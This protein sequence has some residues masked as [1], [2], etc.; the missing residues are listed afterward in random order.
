MS[1]GPKRARTT[2]LPL[3]G[4]AALLAAAAWAL[5]LHAQPIK[6]YGFLPI[7]TGYPRFVLRRT[8]VRVRHRRQLEREAARAAA[9]PRFRL[10]PNATL[11]V[12]VVSLPGASARRASVRQ[13]LCQRNITFAWWD[14]VDGAAALPEDEVR[15]YTSGPR[16]AAFRRGAPGSRAHRK[17]ACDLS[18]L[19]L[20]HD[21]VAQGREVQVVLEDDAQLADAGGDFLARVRG[22]LA[23]L[24]A[25]WDVLWLNH[26]G[27]IARE[28]ASLGPWVG[29]GV[30]TFMDNSDTVGMAYRRSFALV[31][32]AR[33]GGASAGPPRARLGPTDARVAA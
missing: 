29:R 1:G 13:Q 25:G 30:R 26:G 4:L 32:S 24:P 23:Q 20:M 22:A 12:F 14:A 21:M 5:A 17:A 19:R 18:H 10:A 31:V 27:P 28:P 2:R 3:V 16:L 6:I 8:W 15:R 9:G 7:P 11:P 33:A